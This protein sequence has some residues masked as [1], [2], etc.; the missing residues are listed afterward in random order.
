MKYIVTFTILSTILRL[1]PYVW[2]V[3][4]VPVAGDMA[5]EL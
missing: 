5:D 4:Y 2:L 1:I 3:D